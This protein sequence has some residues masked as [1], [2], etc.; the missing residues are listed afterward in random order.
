[1]SSSVRAIAPILAV[2]DGTPTTSSIDVAN[3]FG[4]RHDDVLRAIRALRD[5]V[6]PERARIFAETFHEV[7][8]PNGAVRKDPAFCLTRDGFT[9]LAMGFTGKKALAFK[10]AYMDAFNQMEAQLTGAAPA[11]QGDGLDDETLAHLHALM[12]E[13]DK[14]C[15][16]WAEFAPVLTR[17]QSPLAVRMAQ[18]AADVQD[19]AAWLRERLGPQLERGFHRHRRQQG[20]APLAALDRPGRDPSLDALRDLMTEVLQPVLGAG[21]G[22][23][24]GRAR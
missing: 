10:L 23:S 17:L 16:A 6:G 12:R 14:V 7:P 11:A 21:R 24:T 5:Q 8:G 13:L 3:H 9:L 22:R 20:P 19:L 1:M 4:K 18:P 2:V 15:G